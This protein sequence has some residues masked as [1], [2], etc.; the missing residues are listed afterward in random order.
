M[1][2]DLYIL[3]TALYDYL[4][5]YRASFAKRKRSRSAQGIA[6]FIEVQIADLGLDAGA[7]LTIIRDERDHPV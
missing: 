2:P 3:K 1:R 6:D 7:P 5:A 4:E